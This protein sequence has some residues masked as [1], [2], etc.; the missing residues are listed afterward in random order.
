MR[1]DTRILA[2]AGGGLSIYLSFLGAFHLRVK[3]GW[4]GRLL[5]GGMDGLGMGPLVVL[6]C[7]ACLGGLLLQRDFCACLY[8][9]RYAC[10]LVGFGGWKEGRR[11]M[12]LWIGSNR[13]VLD[14]I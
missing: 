7:L 9:L 13:S 5:V 11:V 3:M 4:V 12:Y 14:L 1:L 6:S 2:A 8:M 10:V